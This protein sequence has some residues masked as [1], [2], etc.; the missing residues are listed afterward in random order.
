M[1]IQVSR[2]NCG[3]VCL[4][5]VNQ[6]DWSQS[7]DGLT[8]RE[9]F[10]WIARNSLFF[11]QSFRTPN[12]NKDMSAPIKAGDKLPDAEVQIWT[13]A[14]PKT[15]TAHSLFSGKK[16]R[17]RP[18]SIC[19]PRIPYANI[20]SWLQS[21]FLHF[22]RVSW[23]WPFCLSV[24][25]VEASVGQGHLLTLLHTKCQC[26]RVYY[27]LSSVRVCQFASLQTHFTQKVH[28][29]PVQYGRPFFILYTEFGAQCRRK[30]WSGACVLQMSTRLRGARE[31]IERRCFF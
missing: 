14:G 5:R 4:L 28:L 8:R 24:C 31:C 9:T 18:S 26:P 19:M 10:A 12:K 16:V 2:S 21:I 29:L 17:G 1:K 15:V 20:L 7:I 25:L 3:C 30:I 22:S 27:T 13:E 11:L 6:G 23:D